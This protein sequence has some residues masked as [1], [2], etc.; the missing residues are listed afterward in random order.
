[1]GEGLRLR[2]GFVRGDRE[3]RVGGSHAPARHLASRT[4][5]VIGVQCSLRVLFRSPLS[6]ASVIGTKEGPTGR[7]ELLGRDFVLQSGRVL[8]A[9]G[10]DRGVDQGFYLVLHLQAYRVNLVD[11][12]TA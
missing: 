6:Y 7:Q 10:P 9:Q 8:M 4:Y 5:Y 11:L 12:D 3:L 1:M 2:F